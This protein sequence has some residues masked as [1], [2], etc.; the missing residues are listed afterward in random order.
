VVLTGGG[1][2]RERSESKGNDGDAGGR[3]GAP[4]VGV[5]RRTF[6]DRKRRSTCGS[7]RGSLWWRF[8]SLGKDD[9]DKTAWR[10]SAQP[11][12]PVA[13]RLLDAGGGGGLGRASGQGACP[14]KA[15]V[16]RLAWRGSQ[17]WAAAA[18][19]LPWRPRPLLPVKLHWAQM[20]FGGP[21]GWAGRDAGRAFGLGPVG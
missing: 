16:P 10:R 11:A 1:E 21:T 12:A 17:G 3:L 5:L 20:G 13:A 2:G 14:L 4:R 19:A 6:G 15:R 7:T 8:F 18:A 9:S